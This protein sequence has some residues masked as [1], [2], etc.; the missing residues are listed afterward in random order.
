MPETAGSDRRVPTTIVAIPG[1]GSDA[2]Y[3][4]RAFGPAADEMGL[5]LVALE[6]STDLVDGH[7]RSLDEIADAAGPLI[8][9]GVSIGAAIALSWA[10]HNP[11]AGVWAALPAWTGDPADAPAAWSARAT[12]AALAA[13]GLEPTIAA[14]AASSPAW[15]A[16]ELSR[17]WRGLHP[18][19]GKQLADAAE[20]HSPDLAQIA[21]LTA[22]LAI[23]AATDDPVHPGEVGR[24]WAAAAPRSA[25]A[26][27][28]L[29]EWG[30]NP[31][32]LGFG[33]ARGW[34]GIR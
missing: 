14:M 10:L 8:V 2:D 22:P 4:H 9:G 17:S 28:T 18:G 11:C 12:V 30:D 29:A 34:L 15:L 33:C 3:V 27:V 6:P 32:V 1:T 21:T 25:L 7:L 13:D 16:A 5:T 31:A 24:A 19:L 20:F 23:T 26:E